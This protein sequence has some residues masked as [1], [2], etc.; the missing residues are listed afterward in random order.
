MDGAG[1]HLFTGP[2]F[3]LDQ[4][5]RISLR[6]NPN[7]IQDV[8]KCGAESHDFLVPLHGIYGVAIHRTVPP[9]ISVQRDC[10]ESLDF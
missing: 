2:G 9:F 6:D 4:C 3:A 5:H 7:L 1:D 10:L 8:L